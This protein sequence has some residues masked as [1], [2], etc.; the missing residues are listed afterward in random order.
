[1]LDPKSATSEIV[2]KSDDAANDHYSRQIEVHPLEGNADVSATLVEVTSTSLCAG[3]RFIQLRC[4]IGLSSYMTTPLTLR[5]IDEGLDINVPAAKP[6]SFTDGSTREPAK[7]YLVPAAQVSPR[8]HRRFDARATAGPGLRILTATQM[9][10]V[11]PGNP[12][13]RLHHS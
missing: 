11:S 2:S 6:R 5:D 12:H 1:M 7:D 9:K 10:L 8:L 13:L 4:K 3:V